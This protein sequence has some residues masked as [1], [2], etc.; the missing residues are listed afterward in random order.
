LRLWRLV[1]VNRFDG[2][3]MQRRWELIDEYL[4][5]LQKDVYDEPVTV[6]HARITRETFQ[7]FVVPN[8]ASIGKLLDVGCGQ[9]LMLQ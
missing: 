5:L 1:N 4:D 3:P 9:G 2:I 8:K 6:N 7:T